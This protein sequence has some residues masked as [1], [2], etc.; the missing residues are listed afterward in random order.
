MS[1]FCILNF[2]NLFSELNEIL[3]S[4]GTELSDWCRRKKEQHLLEREQLLAMQVTDAG[5]ETLDKN[6]AVVKSTLD[7]TRA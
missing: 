3:R 6:G 4:V 2:Y 7:E 1:T 5:M